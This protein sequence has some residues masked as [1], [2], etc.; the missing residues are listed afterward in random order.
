MHNS[1]CLISYDYALPG[2]VQVNPQVFLGCLGHMLDYKTSAPTPHSPS[3]IYPQL[4]SLSLSHYT[5]TMSMTNITPLFCALGNSHFAL[6][7]RYHPGVKLT[8]TLDQV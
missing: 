5:A 6:P 8:L 1:L 2:Q 4:P 3:T 7:D